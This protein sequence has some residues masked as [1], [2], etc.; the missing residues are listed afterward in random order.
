MGKRI[1]K[2]LFIILLLMGIGCFFFE[3]SMIFAQKLTHTVQKGDT[4]WDI[5]EKY[6]GD[7]DLWPKLWQMNPFVTNPHLLHPGDVITLFEK[8]PVKEV[9]HPAKEPPVK[10]PEP[11]HV[12]AAKASASAG[13][14]RGRGHLPEPYGAHR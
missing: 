4:L 11:E 10:E 3:P 13:A 9:K 5:C 6:Y 8:E 12:A 1:K 7:P 2:R 14:T